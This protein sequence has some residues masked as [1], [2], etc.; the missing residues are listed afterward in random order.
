[1]TRAPS[2]AERAAT[3]QASKRRRLR[4]T[5]RC[6]SID[7][8][9]HP[10][11]CSF[12]Y[13]VISLSVPTVDDLCVSVRG[14]TMRIRRVLIENFRSI[15]RLECEFD[16]VTTLIGPNG[17]GKSTVIRALDWFF[18][19]E[20]DSLSDNDRHQGAPSDA[21]IRVKVEFDD[22]TPADREALGDRYCPD[23]STATFTAW[24]T[25]VP[26]ADKTTA[27]ALAFAP[28]EAIRKES[29]ATAKRSAY[30]AL[31]ADRPDL[32]LPSCGSASA[33][34]EAMDEWERAN[35]DGLTEA[36]VSD[37]HF[38]GFNSRGKMAELFSY[39]F[40]SA[41][42][43]ASDETSAAKSSILSQ[44]LQRALVRDDLDRATEALVQSF[45]SEFARVSE[46][47]LGEQLRVL[48]TEMSSE[49]HSYTRGRAVR[50]R[51]MPVT[52]KPTAP[53]VA[54]YVSDST[55]ETPVELQGHGFQRTLLMAALT[56]L[57][58]RA[59]SGEQG[60]M[61]LAIEEPELFQHPTQAKAFASVLRD[62][63]RSRE[64]RTQVAY[65]THSPLFVD[66]RYFDQVRRVSADGGGAGPCAAS[67]ISVATLD[68]VA[69]RLSGFVGATSLQRR[70]EQVCFRYL[71][72]ALFAD[73][74]ILVE[75]DEDAAVL[76]G[77][78]DGGVNSMAIQGICVAP[79]SG[80]SNMMIPYAVLELLGIPALMVVDNDS[81][82]PD[83]MRASG[84][85]DEDV[86]RA[87]AKNASDNRALCRFVGVAEEDFPVGAVAPTIAFVPDTMETL[88]AS[89]LPGWDLTRKTII[90]EGRGVEGK[91]AAT[92]AIAAA[93]CTDSPGPQLGAIIALCTASAA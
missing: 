54:L 31:R 32:G 79:V 80:K 76:E 25:W 90:A 41:D 82:A 37:T 60:Q 18:N 66:A 61:F 89:E 21:R 73:R 33:V 47:H 88:L 28:F 1:V 71:P 51:D 38:F 26:G 77:M 6:C 12:R 56:V 63:A 83:R 84:K 65:A 11:S 85:T 69:S 72:E 17:V 93:E 29:T 15:D 57:S 87:V 74:V 8:R 24:R 20:R 64:K 55:V 45:N 92:Y 34:E 13:R 86:R 23:A 78:G 10:G 3:G 58:K 91:N 2:G 36:E 35:P 40:V 62:L 27:R 67:R 30:G 43:R 46:S 19:G 49:I 22:L 48:S 7:E 14:V 16:D 81:G 53:G 70:W 52:V 9:E 42:L 4:E 39:V 59:R 5:H 50:L 68:D 75:G 44:I